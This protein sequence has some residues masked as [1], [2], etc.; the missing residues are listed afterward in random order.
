VLL[1]FDLLVQAGRS[2]LAESLV[3]RRAVLAEILAKVND[4]RLLFSEGV[5]GP[6]RALFDH[7]GAQGHEGIM[8]KDLRSRYRPGQRSPAYPTLC[9]FFIE[10]ATPRHL[11]G[12]ECRCRKYA[13][14]SLYS[15]YRSLLWL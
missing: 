13:D 7:V 4:P 2:L 8:A 11:Q 3:Q 9:R 1:H 5:V 10:N 14:L 6:G 12:P 15:P